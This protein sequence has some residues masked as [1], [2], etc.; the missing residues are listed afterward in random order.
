V[1][2]VDLIPA[3]SEEAAVGAAKLA[4]KAM[5]SAVP[6]GIGEVLQQP[7]MLP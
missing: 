2:G 6:A 1:L 5:H 3:R 4:L 7:Y